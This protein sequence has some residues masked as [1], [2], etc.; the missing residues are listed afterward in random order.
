MFLPFCKEWLPDN[1]YFKES[2]L[3]DLQ[4]KWI[5][6][7]YPHLPSFIEVH[8]AFMFKLF[9]D[10]NKTDNISRWGIKEV[11]FGLQEALYLKVLFPDAKFLYLKRNLSSA[12]ES[13][14][15]FNSEKEWY[16]EWQHRKAFTPFQ[17]ASH[18]RRLIKEF[19]KAI[20][21]TGGVIIEY[22]DLISGNFD[23]KKPNDY[24]NIE[25]DGSV[26]SKK[27]GSGIKTNKKVSRINLVE[28]VMLKFGD[29]GK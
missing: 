19:A 10:F 12:Y 18:R 21:L 29:F 14:S 16:A 8:R 23:L 27:V 13:Y 9:F 6:N 2:D 5:A 3:N 25:V 11:R 28:R 22:E 7:L 24:C 26:L 15:N 17:F 4:S 20:K 1:Y